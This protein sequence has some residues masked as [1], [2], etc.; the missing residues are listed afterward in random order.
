MK[1][2]L[3]EYKHFIQ[4]NS[5][6]VIHFHCVSCQGK[7]LE[8]FRAKHFY[9]FFLNQMTGVSWSIWRIVFFA[10]G[11]PRFRKITDLVSS[12]VY[13]IW[14]TALGV[15]IRQDSGTWKQCWL[16]PLTNNKPT[17]SSSIDSMESFYSLTAAAVY[18]NCASV[19][20]MWQIP[21]SQFRGSSWPDVL[22]SAAGKNTTG[23][24]DTAL[25]RK[26]TGFGFYKHSSVTTISRMSKNAPVWA[27]MWVDLNL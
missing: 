17:I 26:A 12:C 4:W 8:N 15:W 25:L 14:S 9:L 3:A 5:R 27:Y 22:V 20:A 6:C 24:K 19:Q 13:R 1:P 23:L 11:T 21:S 7:D 16:V 18:P 2:L 10:S